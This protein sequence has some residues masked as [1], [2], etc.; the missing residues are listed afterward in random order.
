M[1][2]DVFTSGSAGAFSMLTLT[3]TLLD[4]P[5]VPMRL[6][7]LGIFDVQGERTTKVSVERQGNTLV[8]VPVSQRGEIGTQN[9]KDGRTLVD[10]HSVRLAMEDVMT[11]DEVQNVRS[12]G[13]EGDLATMQEEAIRRGIRMSNSIEATLEHHRIGAIKGQVLD[14]DGSVV[15]DLPSTFGVTPQAERGTDFAGRAEGQLRPFYSQIIRDIEDELG[16]LPYHHIHCVASSGYMD[17]LTSHPETR[18][19]VKG[20]QAAQALMGQ[21]ARSAP[22]EFAGISFEEYRG[23]VGNTKYVDDDKAH[24]FPVEVPELFLQRFAPA[25]WTDTVNTVGL[26]RY[27]RM[28][29]N[30]NDPRQAHKVTWVVQAHPITMCTR[31]RVLIKAKV[32]AP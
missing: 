12:L 21:A 28:F 14:A 13:S 10:I 30:P 5:H 26:P 15:L 4:Q 32:Q 18:E 31:P 17:A 24:F 16:G 8:L 19:N 3:S 20:W 9:V 25:E 2:F 29:Y 6:G 1:H 27:M 11:A 7:R 22:F 23:K